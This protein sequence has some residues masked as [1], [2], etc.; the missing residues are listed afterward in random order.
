MGRLLMGGVCERFPAAEARLP[1]VE[2]RVGAV[3]A[4]ADGR[5]GAGVPAREALA[6]AAAE[7]VLRAAVLRELRARGVEP[8]RRP[9]NGS[10]STGSSGRATTRTPSTTRVSST[11]CAS[12]SRRWRCRP[13]ARARRQ[14]DR[15]LRPV[16]RGADPKA[17]T[18]SCAVLRGEFRPR[19]RVP[20]GRRAGAGARGG[21]ARPRSGRPRPRRTGASRSAYSRHCSATGH[22]GADR[23]G[24]AGVR[25]GDGEEHG[26]VRAVDTRRLRRSRFR[27]PVRRPSWT[28]GEN[29]DRPPPP[30]PG[31]GARCVRGPHELW[32]SDASVRQAIAHRG[33]RWIGGGIGVPNLDADVRSLDP[34]H[35]PRRRCRSGRGLH[36][37]RVPG[38]LGQPA[39]GGRGHAG[40]GGWPP[41][42]SSTSSPTCS[43]AGS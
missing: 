18:S 42:P 36:H 27:V 41:R 20:R 23:L 13:G 31:P 15:L 9:R 8:R 7:R 16:I 26:R 14:R 40:Q 17:R 5:A 1:R 35:L 21:A 25:V 38:P 32:V 2:R 39:P 6:V 34:P 33:R 29:A 22:V 12:T 19:A 28:W 10:A 24:L 3:G 4:R 43:P 30:F 11:S 37:H